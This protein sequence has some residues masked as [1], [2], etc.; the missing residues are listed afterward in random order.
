MLASAK[1]KTSVSVE[2][3]GVSAEDKAWLEAKI[4]ERKAAKKDKNFELAD[5]VRG[6]VRERGYELVDTREGTLYKKI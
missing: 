3:D 1:E 2:N 6:E 4:E 5:R